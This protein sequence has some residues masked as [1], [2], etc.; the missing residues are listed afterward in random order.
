MLSV[1]I[2]N[3]QEVLELDYARIKTVARA[4]LAGEGL[5][6]AKLTIACMTDE[7]IHALNKRFLNHDE[8]TDVIT[9]P[10]S[11][12]PLHGDLAIS[13]ETAQAA[14]CERGHAPADELLLYVIHGI[15]HL[16]GYDDTTPKK[17]K[18]MRAREAHYLQELNIPLQHD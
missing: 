4:V 14:A 2:A 7:A 8:P 3:Q 1:S 16:C 5:S 18:A 11:T 17:Q 6:Q 10:Y 12:Q 9:F 15:L 13:T